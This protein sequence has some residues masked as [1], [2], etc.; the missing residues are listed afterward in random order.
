MLISRHPGAVVVKFPI[1]PKKRDFVPSNRIRELRL[2]HGLK[3][4][5]LAERMNTTAGQ[6][7]RLETGERELTLHWMQRVAA[8]LGCSPADL[9][10]AEDGGLDPQERDLV[11][12]IRHAPDAGRAAIY[13]VAE[14]QRPFS[15]PDLD[16]SLVKRSA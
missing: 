11:D 7:A 10:L 6:L 4:I 9:L 5:P 2:A 3:L 1:M 15:G 12:T 14:S 13:S 16:P 8:A